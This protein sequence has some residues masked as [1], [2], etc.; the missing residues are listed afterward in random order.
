MAVV[1][2]LIHGP[3]T[4]KDRTSIGSNSL[5]H[6]TKHQILGTQSGMFECTGTPKN[7]QIFFFEKHVPGHLF[8]MGDAF[9]AFWGHMIFGGMVTLTHPITGLVSI[10]MICIRNIGSHAALCDTYFHPPPSPT[11]SCY[12]FLIRVTF[13]FLALNFVY[14]IFS[15]MAL[16]SK[17]ASFDIFPSNT[18]ISKSH[19][20]MPENLTDT[21][22]VG[23]REKK[24]ST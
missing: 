19:Q 17:S 5:A 24:N 21:W 13:I 15:S 23:W 14:E 10:L 9:G 16:F 7:D 2:S 1:C 4:R 18:Q 11:S 12:L 20:N 8:R 6:P 3:T 22:R